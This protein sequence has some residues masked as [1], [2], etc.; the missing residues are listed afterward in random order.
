MLMSLSLCLD[1][2]HTGLAHQEKSRFLKIANQFEEIFGLM[3]LCFDPLLL[4]IGVVPSEQGCYEQ[5]VLCSLWC[6]TFCE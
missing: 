2:S 4:L 6:Y 1:H 5:G 3:R